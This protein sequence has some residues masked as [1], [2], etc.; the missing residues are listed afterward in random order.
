M[1]D[2]GGGELILIILL[3]LILFGPNRIPEFAK[4]FKKG[5]NEVRK[6]QQQFQTQINNLTEEVQKPVN[7]KSK[8]DKD[9]LNKPN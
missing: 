4:Y 8:S 5:V 2:V 9:E 1:F 7:P 3:I 6:A